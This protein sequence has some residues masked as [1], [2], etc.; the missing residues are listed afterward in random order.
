MRINIAFYCYKIIYP[1]KLS[2]FHPFPGDLGISN[3]LVIQGLILTLLTVFLAKKWLRW[4]CVPLVGMAIY[5]LTLLPSMHLVGFSSSIAGDK[6]LYF[7]VIGLLIVL[8]FGIEKLIVWNT[9]RM[10]GVSYALVSS[11]ILI[12]AGSE[13]AVTRRYLRSWQD[14]ISLHTQMLSVY[15]EEPT[16]HLGL[17][18]ALM[19]E[20]AYAEASGH[21]QKAVDLRPYFAKV[22]CNLGLALQRQGK[23]EDAMINHQLAIR[24]RPNL[25]QPHHLMG[26]LLLAK[27][28]FSE[29]MK[30][31]QQAMSLK[32]EWWPP[33][34]GLARVLAIHP[35]PEIRFPDEAIRLA[36]QATART[37]YQNPKVLDTLSL[38]Y[39]SGGE[40][41]RAIKMALLACRLITRAP[42]NTWDVNVDEIMTHLRTYREI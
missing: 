6:Y 25:P 23:V 19:K 17:G 26:D 7:P 37:K 40:F 30:R 12:L 4:T 28:A 2:A 15:P 9:I 1:I 32:S 42:T 29:A 8:A 5:F 33:M 24:Y 16:V 38:A 35:D 41:E 20:R 10:S 3:P 27:G 22:Y 11:L 31:Y 34:D 39:A 21:F 36:E 18:N 14:S 13:A